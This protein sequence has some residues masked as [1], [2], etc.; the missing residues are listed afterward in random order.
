MPSETSIKGLRRFRDGQV[1]G[2]PDGGG[3][4]GRHGQGKVRIE[5]HA[6]GQDRPERFALISAIGNVPGAYRSI[7]DP[8]TAAKAKRR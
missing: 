7:V 3:E 8:A 2:R 6:N 4:A 5:A 1:P